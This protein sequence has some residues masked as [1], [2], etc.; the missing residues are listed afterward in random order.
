MVRVVHLDNG[1][2][3]RRSAI[4]RFR[5]RSLIAPSLGPGRSAML[6]GRAALLAILVV[7]AAA[8][9]CATEDGDGVTLLCLLHEAARCRCLLT[10]LLLSLMHSSA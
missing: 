3:A 8:G 9:C 2:S 4:A 7:G 1:G 10:R 6:P 5:Q